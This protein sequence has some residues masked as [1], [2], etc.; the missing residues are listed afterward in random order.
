M[1][2][3]LLRFDLVYVAHSLMTATLIR[4]EKIIS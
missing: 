2:D 1:L 4:V 3:P